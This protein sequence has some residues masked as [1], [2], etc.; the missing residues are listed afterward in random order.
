MNDSIAV[1]AT[2]T[3]V[4]VD[5][6]DA[7]GLVG[8]VSDDIASQLGTDPGTLCATRLLFNSTSDRMGDTA[9]EMNK[10]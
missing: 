7:A 9:R 5:G 8:V 6:V 2:M 10:N 1:V 3:L 4:L